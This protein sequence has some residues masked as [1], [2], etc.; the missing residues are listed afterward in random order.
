MGKN[1][2]PEVVGQSMESVTTNAFDPKKPGKY[3]ARNVQGKEGFIFD[4]FNPFGIG[5]FA[6]EPIKVTTFG[7]IIVSI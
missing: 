6:D 5:M 4:L 3:K 2:T 1:N 7:F